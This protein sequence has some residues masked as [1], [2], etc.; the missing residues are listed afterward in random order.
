MASGEARAAAVRYRVLRELPRSHPWH[1]IARD[2]T[3]LFELI[4]QEHVD[5]EQVLAMLA[6][7]RAILDAAVDAAVLKPHALIYIP[8]AS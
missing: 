8:A 5:R 2:H 3:S 6:A 7:P 4:T 1:H